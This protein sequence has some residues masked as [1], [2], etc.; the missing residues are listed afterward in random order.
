[1]RAIEGMVRELGSS[2]VPILILAEAGAGKKELARRIHEASGKSDDAFRVLCCAALPAGAFA[3][4]SSAELSQGGTL[5]LEDIG[6][7]SFERQTELL[8]LL[9]ARES[10]NGRGQS[11][12]RLI[13]GNSTD[14][15]GEV[16]AGNFREDLYY[17][18]SGVCL[19]LPP[20][21]QRRADIGCLT[22]FFLEKYAQEF[23]RPVP[24]LSEQTQQLFHDYAWPGNIRELEA[25]AKAIVALGDENL[26]MGGLRAI[27]KPDHPDNGERVSLKQ[28]SRAASR[29][30]EKELILKILNKT[31]W[32]RRRAA[33]ELQ[34]SYKALLYKLKQIG[35]GQYGA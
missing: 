18:I 34:I 28:A 13:C 2:R 17:S 24:V 12:A 11:W 31:R 19:R 10:A 32:N 21:R 35:Y 22:T 8:E 7:M 26:A 1:M 29:E 33:Q 23:R 3:A 5:F 25:A 27:L 15:E 30:A 20:L 14:L 9:S 16:R 6:D 4:N